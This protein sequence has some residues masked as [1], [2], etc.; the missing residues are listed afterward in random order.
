[1]QDWRK[2][3]ETQRGA[4]L[5]LETKNNKN[6]VARWTAGAVLAGAELLKLGYVSRASPKD[7]T[8]HVIL[9]TQVPVERSPLNGLNSLK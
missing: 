1:L 4:V 7:S 8:N 5:A 3:V 6:K 9:A 2:R